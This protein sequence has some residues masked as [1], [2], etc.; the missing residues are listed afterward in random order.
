MK[1]TNPAVKYGII[2]SIILVVLGIVMQLLVL[3][4]LKK[5]ALNP[6]SFNIMKVVGFSIMTLLII[7]GVYV[8]CIVKSMKDY[9][10]YNPEFTYKNLVGQGLTTTLIIAVV[11]SAFSYLYGY[12]IA[13]ESREQ[14][15]ELTKQIYE[16]LKMSDEQ[17][18][19]MMEQLENQNPVRQ[20]ITGIAITLIFGMLTSLIS[21]SILKKKYD[22]N[23]PNQM[24]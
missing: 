10:L 2:G 4:S 5:G 20:V 12:V 23:N 22:F 16:N 14:A 6:E 11:S 21:A 13:P 8:T 17:R 9:R 24:R 7:G 19:K 18:Q 3:S 1:Q 15:L